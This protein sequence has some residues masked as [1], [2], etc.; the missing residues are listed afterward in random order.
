MCIK[1]H[2]AL[3]KDVD[4]I[5]HY[6]AKNHNDNLLLDPSPFIQSNIVRAAGSG[7]RLRPG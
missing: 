6:T 7:R 3:V 2:R 4:V 1:C 5:V